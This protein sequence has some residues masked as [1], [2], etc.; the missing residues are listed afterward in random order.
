MRDETPD[1]RS[2]SFA[3]LG[4]ISMSCFNTIVPHM[5]DIM[6]LIVGN[7]GMAVDAVNISALNNA[8]WYCVCNSFLGHVVKLL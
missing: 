1:V 8:A 2:S 6:A 5:N 4:D 3:L 7:L